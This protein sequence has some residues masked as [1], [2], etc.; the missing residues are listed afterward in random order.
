MIHDSLDLRYFFFLKSPFHSLPPP[1]LP[2]WP[3]LL[4]LHDSSNSHCLCRL[5]P[6]FPKLYPVTSGSA[7]HEPQFYLVLV[8][9]CLHF[10]S[11]EG[12]H[13]SSLRRSL[14]RKSFQG[15]IQLGSAANSMLLTQGSFQRDTHRVKALRSPTVKRTVFR[16][17]Q[18]NTS[19]A[20]QHF[21]GSNI[22][23]MEQIAVVICLWTCLLYLIV[24]FLQRLLFYD[25]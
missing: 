12:N 24:S 9:F 16:I 20:N 7:L 5:S 25:L 1:L 10:S 21:F 19:P 2:V 23:F 17:W 11:G 3:I 15:Q 4:H 13:T 22:L 6:S 14:G 18:W 8:S